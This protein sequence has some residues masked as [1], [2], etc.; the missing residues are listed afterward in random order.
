VTGN[1]AAEFRGDVLVGETYVFQ[2]W[3]ERDGNRNIIC[4]GALYGPDGLV[5]VADQELIRTTGW[6]MEIPTAPLLG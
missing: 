5:A 2:S 3:R 4:G 6:G 1:I